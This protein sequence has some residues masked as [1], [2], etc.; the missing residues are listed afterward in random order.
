MIM[1]PTPCI[2]CGEIGAH[3]G[4]EEH[5]F[6]VIARVCHDASVFG[7]CRGVQRQTLYAERPKAAGAA[8]TTLRR[9]LD[10]A[11]GEQTWGL[12]PSGSLRDRTR[13]WT[14][15]CDGGEDRVSWSAAPSAASLGGLQK[16]TLVTFPEF[17]GTSAG[18]TGEVR[19]GGQGYRL[20]IGAGRTRAG[21]R[22]RHLL[23]NTKPASAAMMWKDIDLRSEDPT[24]G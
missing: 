4:S 5:S 6:I 14:P 1:M 15:C 11:R 23:C 22:E 19:D 16:I 24:C 8:R 21:R 9:Y 7:R 3:H 12:H 10:L 13:E 18:E 2:C 17:Q 20:T